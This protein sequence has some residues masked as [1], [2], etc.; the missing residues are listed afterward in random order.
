[1]GDASDKRHF[2]KGDIVRHFKHELLSQEEKAANPSLYTYRIVGF[3]TH[4]ETLEDL[5]IYRALYSP[6][7]LFARP[8][9]MFLSEVDHDKYPNIRQKYRLEKIDKE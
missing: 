5:V 2:E 9:N 3:A 8:A 7:N 1:M 4:T 6:F